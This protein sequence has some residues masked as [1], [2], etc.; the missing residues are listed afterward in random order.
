MAK[1]EIYQDSAGDYRWRFQSNNGKILAVSE[2]G[3]INRAN[4]EHAIILIKRETS[5]AAITDVVKSAS[6]ETAGESR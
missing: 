2:E 3:Y 6:T 4:C 1:F 5:Q